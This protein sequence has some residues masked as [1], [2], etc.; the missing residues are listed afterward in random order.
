MIPQH[1]RIFRTAKFWEVRT[2]MASFFLVFLPR[3]LPFS[4]KP[5]SNWPD[6]IVLMCSMSVSRPVCVSVCV[7]LQKCWLSLTMGFGA[8]PHWECDV[9][10]AELLKCSCARGLS[11]SSDDPGPAGLGWG[12]EFCSSNTLLRVAVLLVCG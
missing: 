3:C 2:S 4:E 11:C 10:I 5:T 1:G 7:S 6:R 12:L 9:C 8:S